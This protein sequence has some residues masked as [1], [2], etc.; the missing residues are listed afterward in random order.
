MSRP[1]IHPR[2]IAIGLILLAGCLTP[3]VPS[4]VVDPRADARV[5][6]TQRQ[7]LFL[8]MA[9]IGDR[10][11]GPFVIDTGANTLVLDTELARTLGLRASHL[12]YDRALGQRVQVATLDVLQA[13]PVTLRNT[14]MVIL[15]LGSPS[16]A[17][18]LRLAGALGA[19]FF[20][21]VIV[22]FDYGAGAVSC[23]A[24]GSYP[25]A[26]A[27]WRP[28]IIRDQQPAVV[29]RL[30]GDAEG[31]FLLDTG[32]NGTLSLSTAFIQ[33]HPSLELQ[34]VRPT[35]RIAVA[36]E[37]PAF[38]GT[39]RSVELGGRRFDT[40]RVMFQ[41][42]ED[43]GDIGIAAPE[44]FIPAHRFDGLIGNGLMR[45]FVVV[46]NYPA[47]KIAF[48]PARPRRSADRALPLLLSPAPS[49]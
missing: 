26:D 27:H 23:Y 17:L 32:S 25:L 24:P 4:V 37:R 48:L 5:R 16:R 20:A 35:K 2:C 9:R 31:E 41:R 43:E 3:F 46:F 28:L 36:G 1:A 40:L 14:P 6:T 11:A 44:G 39:I 10:D 45:H 13:G 12:S 42:S 22:E 15:D 29:V 18:E 49:A 8:T 34:D 19:P 33:K 30:N 21:G 47:G 7:G 38:E